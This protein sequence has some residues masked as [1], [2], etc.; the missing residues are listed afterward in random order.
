TASRWTRSSWKWSRTEGVSAARS[1][2]ERT[3]ERDPLG[4]AHCLGAPRRLDADRLH[5]LHRAWY[6]LEALSQ[7]LA[8][9]T[10]A[11]FGEAREERGVHARWLLAGHDVDDRRHDLGGRGESRAVDFHRDAGRRPPLGKNAEPPIGRGAHRGNDTLGNLLL[12]HQCEREPPR[13]PS[14]RFKP[15]GEERGPD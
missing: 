15:A 11:F 6:A 4:H 7:H 9:L 14:R 3:C 12:E 1:S 8:A 5:A 13:R 2:P 10:E